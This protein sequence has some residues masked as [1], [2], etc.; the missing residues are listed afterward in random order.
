MVMWLAQIL[1]RDKVSPKWVLADDQV[2]GRGLDCSVQLDD[3]FV[4][5][6]HARVEQRDDG[7]WLVDSQ[8]LN[9]VAT[10]NRKPLKGPVHLT[11]GLEFIMG[12]TRFRVIDPSQSYEPTRLLPTRSMFNSSLVVA[13]V[14]VL[15]LSMMGG[16]WLSGNSEWRWQGALTQNMKLVLITLVWPVFWF[17]ISRVFRGTGQFWASWGSVVAAFLVVDVVEFILRSIYYNLPNLTWIPTVGGFINLIV[18]CWVVVLALRSST[19]MRRKGIRWV[20]AVVVL[21]YS[22]A[23]YAAVGDTDWTPNPNYN[24]EIRPSYRQYSDPITMKQWEKQASSVFEHA[25]K[26]VDE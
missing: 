11:H 10:L 7:Y 2:I 3:P 24:T 26:E 13:L 22:F 1:G 15:L 19:N 25:D 14:A 5:V 12:E 17:F 23:Q 16:S 20:I 18:L 21:L 4:D 6:H 9:G 8:S